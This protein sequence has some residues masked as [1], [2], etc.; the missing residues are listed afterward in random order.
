M[1]LKIRELNFLAGR[2]V[3]ILNEESAKELNVNINER[4]LIKKANFNKSL[5]AI[6]DISKG[7]I[8]KDE[9]A[10]SREIINQLRLKKGDVVDVGAAPKPLSVNYI[11]KKL[12]GKE[13]TYTEIYSIISD[14]VNNHLSEAEIAYFVSGIYLKKMTLQETTDLTKAIVQV[15]KKLEFND[16]RMVLDKHSIGGLAGNR[17]T[18]IVVSIIAAAIERYKL[19]AIMP[20][21]SSRAITSAAGTADVMETIAN[22]EFSLTQIK[23]I[24]N[25]THACL[26]WGGAL[27]LAPADDKII[28][29]ERLLS[30]DPE[31]QLI[32]SILAKKI[33][34]GATHILIDIP[35]GRASKVSPNEARIL[36][37]KFEAV[38]KKLNLN[39]KVLITKGDEPIGNGIGP[40]LELLDVLSVLNRD[41]NRPLDLEKKSLLLATE[42]L[43]MMNIEK[44]KARQI[45]INLLES[46]QAFYAF[47]K[48][49]E[50]QGGNFKNL[51]KKLGLAKYKKT[52]YSN[53][54]GK[55]EEISSKK[56]ANISRLAGTP[57]NKK[58][59]IYLHVHIG[60]LTRKKQPLFDIYSESKDKLDYAVDVAEHSNPI[61][62]K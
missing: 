6:I 4:I 48:I 15:G 62:I 51:G 38:A 33:S 24:L 47:Q 37:N 26:V 60:D 18:P 20:K 57:E 11:S 30:L 23:E 8:E 34:V 12:N 54:N 53:T 1:F 36:K 35:C 43:S 29:V 31:S 14:I 59:G 13:L 41:K 25:R 2:P 3:A 46:R 61:K 55:V 58:A 40:L 42:L 5:V 44:E 50:A 39:L 16:K 28:Q 56:L 32:A 45:C 52:I 10:L 7:I 49:I 27:G 21:T 17:T 19:K 9:I 22:V